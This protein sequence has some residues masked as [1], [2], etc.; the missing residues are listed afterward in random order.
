MEDKKESLDLVAIENARVSYQMAVTLWTYQGSLNWNRFNVMLTA[1]S[2]IVAGIGIILP[3]AR[4]LS[5]FAVALPL[6]G[7]FLC[8]AWASMMARG[9]AY[10]KYWSSRTVEIEEN[11][12][13]RFGIKIAKE[14]KPLE[15]E[16]KR[17]AKPKKSDA[18]VSSA[19]SQPSAEVPDKPKPGVK[20]NW[21]ARRGEQEAVSYIVIG[22]FAV[23]FVL[24]LVSIFVTLRA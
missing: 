12:D 22:I 18:P 21:L 11:E 14:A 5:V 6:M 8:L 19:G 2:I 7:L 23:I 20:F 4:S 10:H 24:A 16:G 3:N 13:F 1:N 9:Y 17:D 15:D